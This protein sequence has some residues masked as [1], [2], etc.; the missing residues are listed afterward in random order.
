MATLDKQVAQLQK[1]FKHHLNC[2]QGCSSCCENV[3]FKISYIEALMLVQGFNSLP[4][5]TKKQV[6]SNVESKSPHCPFL[7]EGSCSAYESRPALCRGYGLLLQVGSDVGT[8]SLNFN[9]ALKPGESLKKL[10][11][12]PYYTVLEELSEPLWQS[13]IAK[14]KAASIALDPSPRQSIRSFMD[15]LLSTSQ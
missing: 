5:N 15:L 4:Q 3:Q 1:E 6:L 8:C 11:M 9:E 12:Q 10:D 2:K 14:A 7:V 13:R